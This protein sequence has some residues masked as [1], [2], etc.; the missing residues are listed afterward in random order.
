VRSTAMGSRSGERRKA[1]APPVRETHSVLA[2]LHD[3]IDRM[4]HE[5]SLPSFFLTGTERGR[6]APALDLYEKNGSLIVE[7]ELPGVPTDAVKI[8]CTDHTLTIQGETNK[9]GE[10]KKEG[11]Y[12]AER[13]YGSFY[14]MVTLPEGVDFDTAKAEFK[15]GVLKITLPKTSRPQEKARTLPITG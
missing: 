5:F 2:R 15:E 1:M 11:Y 13:R 6:W 12:R 7:A 9:E 14:R 8:H 3:E 10:E 4:F